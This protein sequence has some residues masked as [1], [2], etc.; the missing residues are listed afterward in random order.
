MA[1][2][3]KHSTGLAF[4]SVY[5]LDPFAQVQRRRPAHVRSPYTH[6]IT[7]TAIEARIPLV[8]ASHS[9]HPAVYA[10]AGGELERFRFN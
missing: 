10:R 7:R 9:P 8:L 3:D 4:R 2:V 5:R 6:L 1:D